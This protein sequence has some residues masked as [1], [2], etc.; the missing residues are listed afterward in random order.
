MVASAPIL[1][2]IIV[3]WNS[4]KYVRQ[5]IASLVEHTRSTSY[6]II[7][8]DGASYD[9]CAEM[10]AEHFPETKFIQATTN[11]GFARANNLGARHARGKYLLLLNPD[12]L[13]LEDSIAILIA[14]LESNP[15]AG[16]MGCRLL[17]ED[18]TLQT[19]CV[20]AF[21]TLFNQF[22]VSDYLIRRFP[23]FPAWNVGPLYT[24][25][26]V[27]KP[28]QVISGACMLLTAERFW[29]VGGFTESFFMYSEDLDLCYKL[30]KSGHPAYY[31]STTALVHFGG[32]STRQTFSRFSTLAMHHSMHHYMELNRGS[33]YAAL[34]RLTMLVGSA[35]RLVVLAPLVLVKRAAGTSRLNLAWKKW[36]TICAWAAGR[37]KPVVTPQPVVVQPA[38]HST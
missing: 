29:A 8:V 24:P 2:V 4:Q 1:S 6:E 15:D 23:T 31:C 12:T 33:A 11:L 5:C 35:L 22:F 26:T 19:S 37:A 3:N 20:Q 10:L 32:G 7:V 18:R 9:G 28:V 38:A 30:H 17:N 27:P 25:S 34:Y 14:Q 16:L 21:P 36:S 13:L